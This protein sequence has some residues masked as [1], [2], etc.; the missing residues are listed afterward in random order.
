MCFHQSNCLIFFV[1]LV[2][3]S[4]I[5]ISIEA[6]KKREEILPVLSLF[7]FSSSWH[8]LK[9][10]K[11][12]YTVMGWHRFGKDVGIFKLRL[13]IS[14]GCQSN[15]QKAN[16]VNTIIVKFLTWMHSKPAGPKVPH[17]DKLESQPR[18][19]CTALRDTPTEG[20]TGARGF[21]AGEARPE[22]GLWLHIGN[23]R[24]THMDK[25]KKCFTNK[26]YIFQQ[27]LPSMV[28]GIA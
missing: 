17:P 18:L 7:F 9:T 10:A 25:E 1:E 8:C 28:L 4:T 27:I 6:I 14:R 3:I 21:N 11:I 15:P 26:I 20:G 19:R 24:C 12:L 2:Y 13:Y 16:G 5:L 23:G 22:Q